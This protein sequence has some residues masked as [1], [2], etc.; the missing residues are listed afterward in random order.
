MSRTGA[1]A[2]GRIVERKDATPEIKAAV[3]EFNVGLYC[4]DGTELIKALKEIKDDNNAGEYYLTDVFLHLNPVT[5]VK[6]VDPHEA[7]GVKDRV[8]LAAATATIHPLIP[9]KLTLPGPTIVG[10]QPTF[11]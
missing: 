11:I 5:V 2:L 3:H 6:L 4:F 9:D 10:P 1:G 7:M 8:R